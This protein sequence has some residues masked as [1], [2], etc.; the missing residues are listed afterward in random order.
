MWQG[1]PLQMATTGEGLQQKGQADEPCCVHAST[2]SG[3]RMS[4]CSRAIILKFCSYCKCR[5][6]KAAKGRF[7]SIP[8]VSLL[9]ADSY[10]MWGQSTAPV[11][12]AVDPEEQVRVFRT[13]DLGR[14]SC[15]GLLLAGRLDLQAKIGG[16]L[17]CSPRCTQVL[18]SAGDAQQHMCMPL[19]VV[20]PVN[21]MQ[22]PRNNPHVWCAGV[23]F[24]LTEVEACLAEHSH[25]RAAAAKAWPTPTGSA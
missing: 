1:W 20:D 16:A 24:D 10:V 21:C 5:P 8:R 17:P 18:A 3:T 12:Q 23:R 19:A 15:Q 7:C 14:L 4:P 2:T 22:M 9:A 11:F 25:V 6:D 13:G